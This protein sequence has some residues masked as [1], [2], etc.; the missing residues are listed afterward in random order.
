LRNYLSEAEAEAEAEQNR[1]VQVQG[2][3]RQH[4]NYRYLMK[5]DKLMFQ[6]ILNIKKVFAK[7]NFKK[8]YIILIYF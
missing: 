8:I 7:M 4:M 6:V 5:D 1:Y 2:S 3:N